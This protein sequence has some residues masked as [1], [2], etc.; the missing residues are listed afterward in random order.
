MDGLDLGKWI[1]SLDSLLGWLDLVLRVAVMAGPL[2]LLGLGLY[3]FLAAPKE[4]NWTSGYRFRYGMAKARSW[5]F[6]QRLAGIV[7][8]I[9][10]LL[11]TIIMAIFC[12]RF[13]AM[14]PMTMVMSAL[15]L[16][17]WEVGALIVC[18]LGVNITVMVVF[19]PEGNRRSDFK[20]I[21]L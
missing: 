13:Q 1:P 9:A 7:F 20:G 15:R 2:A 11:L 5:Q 16:L 19:D 3:Y 6:M 8:S 14:E 18:T 12:A 21:K 10:G 4:A 17:L